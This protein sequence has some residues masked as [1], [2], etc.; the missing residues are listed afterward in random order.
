MAAPASSEVLPIALRSTLANADEA[1]R[2]RLVGQ[3]QQQL[4]NQRVKH[5]VDA[6]VQHDTTSHVASPALA[7]SSSPSQSAD[8]L[9]SHLDQIAHHYEDLFENQ[10]LGLENLERDLETKDP[11]SLTEA[12]LTE[13]ISLSVIAASGAI[14]GMVGVLA[15]EYARKALQTATPLVV[16]GIADGVK[17]AVKG[18]I[19]D[20]ARGATASAG[21]RGAPLLRQF[22][23][24]SKFTLNET[25]A[26]A[27]DEFIAR[28]N[29]L[30]RAPHGEEQASCLLEALKQQA[31]AAPREQY[32][33]SLSEW[34]QILN[35]APEG[36][37]AWADGRG[38]PGRGLEGGML[39]VELEVPGV[40]SPPTVKGA[41]WPGL[42]EQTRRTLQIDYADSP[43]WALNPIV[44][45]EITT[46]WMDSSIRFTIEKFPGEDHVRFPT[47]GEGW[48]WL[49]GRLR[50]QEIRPPG[51]PGEWEALT[52]A[53]LIWGEMMERKF[54]SLGSIGD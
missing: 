49:A 44:R 26:T 34:S 13:A 15:E 18:A 19:R 36:R 16:K 41:R 12:L 35:G 8:E 39:V 23:Q 25:K 2:V 40:Q 52:A 43:L 46:S 24:G 7:P 4:G 47:S 27:R 17:D 14:G 38:G 1:S 53:H 10:K 3:L 5:I 42:N 30:R 50:R 21:V 31:A 45:M 32:L 33:K 48:Y 51:V 9:D 20:H 22:I 6:V 29:E 37:P 28:R 54:S 11:P